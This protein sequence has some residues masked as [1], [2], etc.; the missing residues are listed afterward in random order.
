MTLPSNTQNLKIQN[1]LKKCIIPYE[2]LW[3]NSTSDVLN[4]SKFKRTMTRFISFVKTSPRARVVLKTYAKIFEAPAE[5]EIRIRF[6]DIRVLPFFENKNIVVYDGKKYRSYKHNPG[7]VGECIGSFIRCK[8]ET[9][10]HTK[11]VKVK[12]TGKKQ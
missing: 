10:A 8:K 7:N 6:R 5:K 3:T 12:L 9:H 11:K 1:N 4:R 2:H